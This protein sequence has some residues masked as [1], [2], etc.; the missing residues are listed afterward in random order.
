M[1]IL[2]L[3]EHLY[4]DYPGEALS[5]LQALATF[6]RVGRL[7]PGQKRV[8]KYWKL[9]NNGQRLILPRGLVGKVQKILPGSTI[10]DERLLVPP[11]QFGF[12][13]DLRDYQ[14]QAIEAV[15]RR[16]GG[17]IVSDPASGKTFMGLGLIARW[18]QPTLFLV[19]TLRLVDQTVI[20]ARKVFTLPR[21]GIG[22]IAEGRKTIGSHITVAT[23]Q[24]LASKPKYIRE[25]QGKIGT[26]IQDEAHHAP[27]ISFQR[28]ISAFPA[29]YR[30]SLTGT[31][32]REDGLGGMINALF[33]PSI[34]VPRAVLRERGAV[35][36]PTVFLVPTH[37]A[38]P[39]DVPYHEAEDLRA[40]D[41]GRNVILARLVRLVRS[42]QLRVLVL[43]EREKHT[44]LLAQILSK[45]SVPAHPVYGKLSKPLQDQRFRWMEQGKAVVVATKLANEGLDWPALDVAIFGAPG[46][47][48]TALKQRSGRISR[49]AP[50]KTAA[51]IYDLAD[52]GPLYEDQTRARVEKYHEMGYRVRRFRWPTK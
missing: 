16:R 48:G 44:V 9:I 45:I 15:E 37:W 10:R 23:V 39:D 25:L 51:I 19:H 40:T 14:E 34:I 49:T 47:S 43:V 7:R 30:A 21:K 18:Q 8:V 42:Q 6:E 20:E 32:D 24:T 26:I 50:G 35:I 31:P 5:T 13:A 36:D 33:G 29:Y 12:R 46:R 11:V 2:T 27:A 38:P 4:V 28:V 17:V 22:V 52:D 41:P 1:P 3:R